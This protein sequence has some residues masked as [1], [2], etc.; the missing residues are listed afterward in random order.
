MYRVTEEALENVVGHARASQ[1]L[2]RLQ[3]DDGLVELTVDDDG[4]G[5]DPEPRTLVPEGGDAGD[6]PTPLGLLGMHERARLVG[7]RLEVTGRP[8]AGTTVRL[9]VPS[10]PGPPPGSDRAGEVAR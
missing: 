3:V 9:Q 4:L 7:G 2:V 6:V 10:G 1:I 5:F 8:G